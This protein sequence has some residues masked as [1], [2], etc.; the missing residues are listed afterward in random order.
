[1][2]RII[3]WFSFIWI[4]VLGYSQINDSLKLEKAKNLHEKALDFHKK[5][6]F[7]EAL[8]PLHQALNLLDTLNMKK[9][10]LYAEYRHDLSILYLLG[11]ND[12]YRF[13]KTYKLM[14]A[15][16]ALFGF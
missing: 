15:Y 16:Y 10:A 13:E 1:M 14:T 11:K 9:T 3:I 8:N 2:R 7:I 12:I 4:S 6:N 5:G